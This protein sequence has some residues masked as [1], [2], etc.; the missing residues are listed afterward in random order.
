MTANI[1]DD[2]CDYNCHDNGDYSLSFDGVDDYVEI[3][4]DSSFSQLN[5]FTLSSDIK[6]DIL[7]SKSSSFRCYFGVQSMMVPINGVSILQFS[8]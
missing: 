7:P 8:I 2:S 1:S 5:E 4:Y 3:F 6:I